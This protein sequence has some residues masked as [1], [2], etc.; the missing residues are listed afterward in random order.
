[1]KKFLIICILGLSFLSCR[2]D[3]VLEPT[4]VGTWEFSYVMK[5]RGSFWDTYGFSVADSVSTTGKIGFNPEGTGWFDNNI[6]LET[7]LDKD[8]IWSKDPYYP[9]MIELRFK[10]ISSYGM[11][12]F[13][14]RDSG[15]LIFTYQSSG[16]GVGSK[17]CYYGID[18]ERVR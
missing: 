1:M 10:G 15:T 3:E 8:F 16:G 17:P 2:K 4:L 18:L 9:D 11:M 13:D 5:L 7:L 14:S 12:L 6:L